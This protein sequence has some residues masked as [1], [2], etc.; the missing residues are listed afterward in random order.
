MRH[1]IYAHIIWTTR[2]RDALIDAPVAAFLAEQIRDIAWRERARLL[3]VG[4]VSTHVHVLLRLHPTVNLPRLVQRLKG[5]TSC[6]AGKA[7]LSPGS[8]LR[9]DRGYSISS[10]SER[11]VDAVGQ[12]VRDQHL[13]H[14]GDAIPGWPGTPSL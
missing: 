6:E 1:R 12:Y 10:V 7:H 8:P 2:G 14:P 4:I 9:W 3:E 11:A 13:R 5:R